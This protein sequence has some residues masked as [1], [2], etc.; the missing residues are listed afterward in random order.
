MT[1]QAAANTQALDVC[2]AA[3]TGSGSFSLDYRVR[4]NAPPERVFKALTDEVQQWW[5]HTYNDNPAAI[6]LE[7]QLGGRFMELWDS[8]G[9]GV[10]L[11]RVEIFDPPKV[12]R[13]RGSIGMNLAV[14]VVYTVTLEE[15]EG[16]TLLHEA[17]R[18]SGEVSERLKS[19][20]RNGTESESGVHLRNWVERGE[21]IR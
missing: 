14:D 18:I 16:G 8:E 9:R 17:A 15:M 7:P 2:T 11:G 13:V 1:E 4:L 10:L 12:L 19:G 6:V 20:M 3:D 21:S 5:P